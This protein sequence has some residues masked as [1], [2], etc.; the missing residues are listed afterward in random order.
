M[1]YD[2]SSYSNCSST[3]A[4]GK[5]KSLSTDLRLLILRG[6]QDG[7]SNR[8]LGRQF[9]CS[10]KAVRDLLKR[11]DD[12]GSVLDRPRSGRPPKLSLRQQRT[13]VRSCLKDRRRTARDHQLE[14]T[15]FCDTRLS[16]TT[17]R[18]ILRRH[19]LR[20]CIATKKPFISAKNRKALFQ[21][22]K[23]HLQWTPQKWSTVLFSDEKTFNR[24]GSDGRVYVRR[25]IGEA[26]LPNCL[27]GTVKGGGGS[28]MAWAC[29]SAY[30]TGP[31]HRIHGIMNQHVYRQIMEDVMLPHAEENMP[32]RWWLQQD[33]DPKHSKERGEVV[34]RR[35]SST[36]PVAI[37]IARPKPDRK[38][39]E[40]GRCNCQSGLSSHG[41]RARSSSPSSLDL[42]SQVDVRTIGGLHASEMRSCH[43]K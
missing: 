19:G 1:F 23:H 35:T 25:R 15:K 10:E 8:Q 14:L 5:R 40:H 37:S 28:L 17:A 34:S 16:L 2:F 20:G 13:I 36:A 6:K 9:G 29:F 22:A 31:V 18:R 3:E 33:N 27:R 38:P 11:F 26:L 7:I 41:E 42:D 30:G 43:Q 4:M 32:L 12:T 39:L 21:W 24:L